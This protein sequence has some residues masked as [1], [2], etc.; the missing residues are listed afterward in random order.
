MQTASELFT[1]YN[2]SVAKVRV[3]SNLGLTKR[4]SRMTGVGT[5]GLWGLLLVLSQYID[6]ET[7]KLSTQ[8]ES[9]L[10]RQL[11]ACS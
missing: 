6:D 1:G 4:V 9:V 2:Q 11:C 7:S 3:V 10:F 5:N 8:L